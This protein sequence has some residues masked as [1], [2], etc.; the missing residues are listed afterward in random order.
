[1]KQHLLVGTESKPSF[2]YFYF[3]L[4]TG[5]IQFKKSNRSNL[6]SGIFFRSCAKKLTKKS[7]KKYF[8]AV[9]AK[10]MDDALKF[11][12]ADFDSEINLIDNDSQWVDIGED[13]K[14]SQSVEDNLRWAQEPNKI[15]YLFLKSYKINDRPTMSQTIVSF[16]TYDCVCSDQKTTEIALYFTDELVKN[17]SCNPL[18]KLLLLKQLMPTSLVIPR[19]AFCF[20]MLDFLHLLKMNDQIS[21]HCIANILNQDYGLASVLKNCLASENAERKIVSTNVKMQ[22]KRRD[23]IS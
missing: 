22:L 17:Y 4:K 1:M 18:F 15:R 20:G 2:F 8:D 10:Q 16:E 19:K 23:D 11:G 14:P 6:Y 9:R 7:T 13:A 21:N 12:Q 5:Y 3:F